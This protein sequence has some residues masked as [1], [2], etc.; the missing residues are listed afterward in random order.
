MNTLLVI[1]LAVA[2]PVYALH[3]H[4]Q[5]ARA[6]KEKTTAIEAT[7]TFLFDPSWLVRIAALVAHFVASNIPMKWPTA[8]LHAHNPTQ[9]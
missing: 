6:Q 2:I 7:F 5:P 4:N 9:I 8:K 3:W 1:T